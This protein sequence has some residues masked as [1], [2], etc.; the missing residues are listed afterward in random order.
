[1]LLLI[2]LL[3]LLFGGGGGYYGHQ[4]MGNGRRLGYW[5]DGL[6][7]RRGAVSVW[8]LASIRPQWIEA[9]CSAENRLNYETYLSRVR[10][11][12]RN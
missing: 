10:A 12:A 8:R 3:V 9:G 6:A 1:M 5:R 11:I 4:K 7:Y 2:I